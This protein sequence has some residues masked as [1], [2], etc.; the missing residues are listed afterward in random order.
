M[1]QVII[2]MFYKSNLYTLLVK[3]VI[4]TRVSSIAIKGHGIRYA[5]VMVQI[6]IKRNVIIL[7]VLKLELE[8]IFVTTTEFRFEP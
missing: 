3:I 8:H 4:S 5:I 2:A 6:F 7:F 1:C